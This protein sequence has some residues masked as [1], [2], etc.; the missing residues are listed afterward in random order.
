[1]SLVH[2]KTRISNC[3]KAF[4]SLQGAGMC[5]NGVEPDIISYLW[6]TA[7]QPILLYGGEC[8]QQRRK[9]LSDMVKLQSRLIK[10]SLGLK[11]YLRSTPLLSALYISNIDSTINAQ[12]LQLFNSVMGNSARARKFYCYILKNLSKISCQTTLLH[13]V[14]SICDN[15]T[16]GIVKTI[17][18]RSSV[19]TLCKSM[20]RQGFFN[21]GLVDSCRQLLRQ[22]SPNNRNLLEML[23]QPF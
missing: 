9:N 23:L 5:S 15:R 13:R 10:T 17:F 4:Y 20:K 22:F 16:F 12:N 7:I 11:K 3:R 2:V 6:K 21:E 1:M 8:F 18:S 14:I 19:R